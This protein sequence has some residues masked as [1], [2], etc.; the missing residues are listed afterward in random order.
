MAFG[1]APPLETNPSTAPAPAS[2]LKPLLELTYRDARDRL[3][4][5]FQQAY[6]TR[7]L[8]RSDGNVSKAAALAR[9]SRTHLIQMIKQHKI[10]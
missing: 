2:L 1:G 6:F 7:L 9:M 8:E 10:R 4:Q 5:D 3:M